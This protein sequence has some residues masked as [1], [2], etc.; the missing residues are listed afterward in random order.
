MLMNSH[1]V[2]AA[3]QAQPKAPPSQAARAGVA[4]ATSHASRPMHA[5]ASHQAA[6]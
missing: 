3:S 2:P 1:Q 4:R 6:V 5:N